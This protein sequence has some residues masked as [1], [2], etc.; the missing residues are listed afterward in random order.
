MGRFRKIIQTAQTLVAKIAITIVKTYQILIS[1]ILGP[2]CRFYPSCSKYTI[3]AIN[4]F[5]IIYGGYLAIKRILRCNP[6]F[7]GGV[8]PVPNLNKEG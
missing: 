3:D 2:R 4:R 8:D 7:K 1:P 5:G 6:L